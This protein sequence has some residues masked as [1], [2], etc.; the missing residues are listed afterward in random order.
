MGFQNLV[1]NSQI[2]LHFLCY[3]HE[4]LKKMWLH[5]NLN[6]SLPLQNPSKL[7]CALKIETVCV[8]KIVISYKIFFRTSC[9][10]YATQLLMFAQN[11][12]SS[13]IKKALHIWSP[14]LW[15]LTSKWHCQPNFWWNFYMLLKICCRWLPVFV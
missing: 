13:G 11:V 6:Y 1:H 14:L 4:F 3:F 8:Q 15:T 12:Y 10:F 5:S 7:G 2:S 9:H